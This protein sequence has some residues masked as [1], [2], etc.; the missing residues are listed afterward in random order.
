MEV[1]NKES[2]QLEKIYLIHGLNHHINK[3]TQIILL[4]QK[5]H[6][7]CNRLKKNQ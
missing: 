4:Y 2:F 7:N 5:I 3:L 6:R 1:N